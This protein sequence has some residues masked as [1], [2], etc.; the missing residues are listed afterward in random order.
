MLLHIF[1]YIGKNKIAHAKHPDQLMYCLQKP[2]NSLKK[3][4]M[5]TLMSEFEL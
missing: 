5:K 3:N 2:R 1:L 4:I